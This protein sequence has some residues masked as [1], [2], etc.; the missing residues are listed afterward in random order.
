MNAVTAQDAEKEFL[1][2]FLW[3]VSIPAGGILTL[4]KSLTFPS[5][6]FFWLAAPFVASGIYIV[7]RRM[8][9]TSVRSEALRGLLATLAWI[10]VLIVIGVCLHFMVRLG[11][12]LSRTPG[13][14]S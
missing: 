11:A 3:V 10:I 1:F 12:T 14:L 8:R 7:S 13:L 9:P 6:A 5:T 2:V 4:F